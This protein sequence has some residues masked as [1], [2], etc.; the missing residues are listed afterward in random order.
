MIHAL[1]EDRGF[2]R[3]SIREAGDQPTLEK[4]KSQF[5]FPKKVRAE[6]ITSDATFETVAYVLNPP[7]LTA[8]TSG[9][10]IAILSSSDEDGDISDFSASEEEENSDE[11]AYELS[12]VSSLLAE[13]EKKRAVVAS[14]MGDTNVKTTEAEAGPSKKKRKV[15]RPKKPQ[16]NLF[17]RID[18]IEGIC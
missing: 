13:L 18:N 1:F 2:V 10:M 6:P 9:G 5:L 16:Y 3:K 14:Q 8:V 7:P 4:T 11:G 12:S 17:D 15:H